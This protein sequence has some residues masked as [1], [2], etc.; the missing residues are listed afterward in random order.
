MGDNVPKVMHLGR[1]QMVVTSQDTPLPLETREPPARSRMWRWI[2][3][4]LGNMFEHVPQFIRR[5]A[6]HAG[7]CHVD[8]I[9][10][11]S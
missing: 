2:K 8:E 10:D 7:C 6:V 3:P 9:G 5:Q 1:R 11:Y 4:G